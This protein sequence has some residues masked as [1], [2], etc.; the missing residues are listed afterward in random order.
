MLVLLLEHEGELVSKQDIWS[1]IWPGMQVEDANLTNTIAS[2]RR[3]LGK[4]A[5]QTHPKHGYQ[6]NVRLN[7]RPGVAPEIQALFEEANALL[8]LRT[9]R[10]LLRARN[11]YWICLA[12]APAYAPAWAWLGRC[13]RFIA[14]YGIESEESMRIAEAAFERAL[15]LEPDLACA[16]QFYAL[17]EADRGHASKAM[18]RLIRYVG[19]HPRDAESFAGLINILRYCGL[20]AESVAAHQQVR[21]LDSALPTSVSHTLFNMC[22]YAGVIDAYSGATQANKRAYLDLAAWAALQNEKRASTLARERLTGDSL[23]H[24]LDTLVRSLLATI[25]GER[26]K[27]RALLVNLPLAGD[28][29]SALYFARHLSRVGDAEQSLELLRGAVQHGYGCSH[30]LAHDPWLKE[31][32]RQDGYH[33]IF[34]AACDVETRSRLAFRKAGGERII[35][36]PGL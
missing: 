17:M 3:V 34:R 1:A 23:P 20:L 6:I 15:T 14:K 10:D 33:E 5:V 27:V 36:R 4:S 2:I 28:P 9:S 31:I 22:D 24:L 21:A 12:N 13:C 18:V 30:I 16:Q 7:S 26:D 25:N 11:L 29:E 8:L 32:R 19:A 35:S